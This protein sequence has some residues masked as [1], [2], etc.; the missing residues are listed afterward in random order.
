MVCVIVEGIIFLAE[1]TMFAKS[2]WLEGVPHAVPSGG[3]RALERKMKNCLR[4]T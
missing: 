3:H 4:E 2:L 1:K